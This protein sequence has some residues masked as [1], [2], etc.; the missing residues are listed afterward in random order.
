MLHDDDGRRAVAE[1]AHQLQRRVSVVIIIVTQFLALDLL[2]LGNAVRGRAVGQV[3]RGRLVRVLAIA[4]RGAE[5]ARQR[6]AFGEGDT[7]VGKGEPA[8]DHRIIGG[9]GGIGLGRQHPAEIIAG[10]AALF[11]HFGDQAGIVGRIGDDRDTLMILRGRTDHRRA[12]DVDILDDLVAVGALGDGRG[13]GI[14]VDDHQVDRADFMLVHR[15]DMLGIVAHGQQPAMDLGV[16]R[17]DAAVH[18]LGEAGQLGNILHG[19]AR[20]AQRLGSAAGR[21]QFDAMLAQCLAQFDEAGLVRYGKE[22]ALDGDV[23]GHGDASC[24]SGCRFRLAAAL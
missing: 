13:E 3:E 15:R 24:C 19:Q 22:G 17:L 21:H 16:Q 1:F 20:L 2:G 8:G 14:E 11:G 23:G 7:L 12:T 9:G 18:H 4:Q 6:Q 10:G 5:L